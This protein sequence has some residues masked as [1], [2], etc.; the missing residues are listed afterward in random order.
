MTA[1]NL[2]DDIF[3]KL[4]LEILLLKSFVIIANGIDINFPPF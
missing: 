1:F 3:E 4:G 2:S